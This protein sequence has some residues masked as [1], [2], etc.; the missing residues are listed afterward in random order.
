[1]SEEIDQ[2]TQEKQN[3]LRINIMDA[4]YDPNVFVEFLINKK[5]EAG[6]DVANWSLPDLKNVVQEF[7]KLNNNNSN[8]NNNNNQQQQQQVQKEENKGTNNEKINVNEIIEIKNEN[9]K[10]ENINIQNKEKG[11]EFT[12]GILSKKQVQCVKVTNNE[13][14]NCENVKITV[15]SFEKVEGNFF[16]IK[17]FNN[18]FLLKTIINLILFFNIHY[19]KMI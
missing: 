4:G 13:I 9:E 3:Y 15:G 16:F 5:G 1:M 11:E 18:L 19:N 14:G 12:Y 7:I 2:E 6:A 10:K 17:I 8:N